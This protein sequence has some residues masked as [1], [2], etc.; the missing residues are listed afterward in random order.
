M[1]IKTHRWNS[2]VSEQNVQCRNDFFFNRKHRKTRGD[3]LPKVA[4]CLKWTHILLE[5]SRDRPKS[6]PYTR[7]KN[8]KRASKCQFTVL[9]N[10]KTKQN[11][12]SGAPGPA[13]ASPWR[14]KRGTLPK[15]S[16]FLSQLKGDPLEKTNFRKKS[17]TMPKNWKGDPSGFLN[18]Q[19]VVKYQRN[20][21]GTL[22]RENFLAKSLTMPKN[23]KG[24]PFGVFQHPFCRKTSTNWRGKIFIFGKKVSQCRKNWKRHFGLAR[25]GML[26][27][28]TGKAFL[29][30]FARPNGAICC[31]NI[32]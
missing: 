13:S 14:A 10:R 16:T 8:S 12:P 5:T 25:Y 27:R 28:K 1:V 9:E 30:Q 21:R 31:N 15:L 23:W 17:L 32:L 7:L 29:V 4:Q 26:R 20:W 24:G 19:S 2:R 11:G 3:P 6:G 18:T 22:W